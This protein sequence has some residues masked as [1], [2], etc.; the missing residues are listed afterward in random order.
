MSRIQVLIIG[1]GAMGVSLLYHLTK[2]GW[3]DVL[4]V[5]KNDLTHGSTWHA[6]GAVHA[7]CLQCHNPGIACDLGPALPGYPA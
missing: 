5:E 6:G 4:L 7:F 2:A 3:S 1:G